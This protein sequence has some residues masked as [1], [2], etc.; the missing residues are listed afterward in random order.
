LEQ[1]LG[2]PQ[3]LAR[4]QAPLQEQ[5]LGPALSQVQAHLLA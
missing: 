2:L 5:Q 4:S 3:E 1:Q